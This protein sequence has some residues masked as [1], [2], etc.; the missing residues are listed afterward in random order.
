MDS[1]PLAGPRLDV[2]TKELDGNLAS[3]QQPGTIIPPADDYRG[4]QAFFAAAGQ[5]Q[6]AVGVWEQLPLC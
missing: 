4:K 5:N 2:P 3:E 1:S 6:S